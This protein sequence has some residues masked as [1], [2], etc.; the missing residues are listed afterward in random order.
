MTQHERLVF[1]DT[2][3]STDYTRS[4]WAR[5]AHLLGVEKD[6]KV[7]RK[8]GVTASRVAAVRCQMGIPPLTFH[9]QC[10]N[11]RVDSPERPRIVL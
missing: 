8:I 10:Q 4:K 11:Y 2:Y 6:R 3:F 9:K 5:V 7:A 1:L